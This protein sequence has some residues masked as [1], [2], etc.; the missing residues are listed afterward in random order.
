[1]TST[2]F[3]KSNERKSRDKTKKK[4]GAHTHARTTV[5]LDEW[6]IHVGCCLFSHNNPHTPQKTKCCLNAAFSK[7]GVWGKFKC[8]RIKKRKKRSTHA[9]THNCAARE[10][11][12]S[13]RLLSIL[14]QQKKSIPQNKE[15]G[16][17]IN[18]LRFCGAQFD[19]LC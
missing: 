3:T 15:Y 12:Y 9:C 19:L 13:R 6:N 1:M 18:S 4:N 7:G 16:L 11:Q 5:Q 17:V 10:T 8:L 2:L 14:A